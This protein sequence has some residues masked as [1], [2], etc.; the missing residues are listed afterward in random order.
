LNSSLAFPLNDQQYTQLVLRIAKIIFSTVAVTLMFAFGG[1]SFR[2]SFTGRAQLR[3]D[4]ILQD[5]MPALKRRA[6]I[7]AS[8]GLLVG[9]FVAFKGGSGGKW[10]ANGDG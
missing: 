9:V 5:T 4:Y 8:V 6:E 2:S 7:G 3:S 1:Y 10:G